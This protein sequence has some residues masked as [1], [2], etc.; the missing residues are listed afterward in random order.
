[1]KEE[2]DFPPPKPPL[3][4]ELSGLS[5]NDLLFRLFENH[6]SLA[7]L[8]ELWQK[9]AK[10]LDPRLKA[11]QN[12][13]QLLN[14]A[15]MLPDSLPLGEMLKAVE[16]AR[17]LLD[18]PDPIG[19]I[20]QAVSN[21]LQQALKTTETDEAKTYQRESSKLEGH[22]LWQSLPEGKQSEILDFV[23]LVEPGPLDPSAN[24]LEALSSA[25]LEARKNRVAALPT[26]F[27]EALHKAIQEAEPKASKVHLSPAT[28]KTSLEVDAW[29]EKTKSALLAGLEKGPVIVG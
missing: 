16:E 21:L 2:D 6:E 1:M 17:T 10:K 20:Q 9:T 3:L 5:G 19:P 18:D 23:G 28:L 12:T 26:R 25:N 7:S 15:K 11:Y 13:R 27:Q 24:L 8:I 29:L 22:S 4:E 14:H